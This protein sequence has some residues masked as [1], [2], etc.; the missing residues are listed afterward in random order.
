MKTRALFSESSRRPEGLPSRRKTNTES[1]R[2]W[3]NLDPLNLEGS[4]LEAVLAENSL[5]VMLFRP[6]AGLDRK[7][8]TRQ[9]L[10]PKDH[11]LGDLADAESP[12]EIKE[13]RGRERCRRVNPFTRH[14]I[15]AIWLRAVLLRSIPSR[16]ASI[17][18]P[19][20]CLRSRGPSFCT[21]SREGTSESE[22][23]DGWPGV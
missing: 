10:S 11:I 16:C 14:G 21:Q 7:A 8:I 18:R 17:E 22:T 6:V 4:I 3:K 19:K 20:T 9:L 23:S 15:T 1:G 12:V 2:I 5:D 13:V